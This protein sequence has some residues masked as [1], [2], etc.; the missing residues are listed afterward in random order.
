LEHSSERNEFTGEGRD[1]R[2]ETRSAP[3]GVSLRQ[4]LLPGTEVL[5]SNGDRKPV[6]RL[7]Q[8]EH[9]FPIPT[10]SVVSELNKLPLRD[11]DVMQLTYL[12]GQHQ[13]EI[14][15]RVTTNHALLVLPQRRKQY[16]SLPAAD[17]KVGDKLRA[18]TDSAIIKRTEKL[19]LNT[20]VTEITLSDSSTTMLVASDPDVQTQAF[21]QVYGELAPAPRDDYVKV[22]VF[23]R[24]DN[25]QELLLES[26]ELRAIRNDL[27]RSGF[28]ADLSPL[29]PAKLFV[30]S[31]L[32]PHVTRAIRERRIQLTAGTVIVSHSFE[33][34]VLDVVN[35][36]RDGG[37]RNYVRCQQ[38]LE[39]SMDDH[40]LD[41]SRGNL[42]WLTTSR[43][44]CGSELIVDR[45]FLD[46]R[47]ASGDDGESAV[48]QS[49]YCAERTRRLTRRERPATRAV[50]F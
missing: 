48:T 25:F 14:N 2:W 33:R 32:V 22:L 1:A 42:L 23:R 4:C 6:D 40:P 41:L 43:L 49:D 19:L 9:L 45:T 12:V 18:L 10:Q 13:A 28:S 11:R 30:G 34:A 5:A 17:I 15:L 29:G 27:A 38:S 36:G 39:W 24:H 3:A 44:W 7:E 20:E 26:D 31:Y 16:E 8:G 47:E 37:R 35:N 46:L 50:A 21:V